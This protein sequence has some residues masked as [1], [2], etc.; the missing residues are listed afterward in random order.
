MAITAETLD[1]ELV[2]LPPYYPQLNHIEFIW[3]SIKKEVSRTFVMDRDVL[4]NLVKSNFIEFSKSSST[5]RDWVEK[6]VNQ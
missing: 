3:K 1:S 5:C 2:F 4:I 6:F